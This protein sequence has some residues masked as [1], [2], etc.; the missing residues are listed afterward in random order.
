MPWLDVP[1]GSRATER[2]ALTLELRFSYSSGS[3]AYIGTG[4]TRDI[5]TGGVCFEF[6]QDL[7]GR[8]DLELRIALPSRLQQVCPLELVVR[9]PLLRKDAAVAVLRMDSYEVRTCGN[10]SFY[11]FADRGVTCDV[12]L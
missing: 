8:S 5:G 4:R 9:G 6:D 10:P 1:A 11:P 7:G 12:S 3:I 2:H